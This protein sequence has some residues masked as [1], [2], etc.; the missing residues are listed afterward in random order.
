M[1]FNEKWCKVNLR[2]NTFTPLNTTLK[3]G[4][5]QDYT[6]PETKM[7]VSFTSVVE[8]TIQIN[9]LKFITDAEYRK[10]SS[11]ILSDAY[12]ILGESDR[13]AR[14]ARCS[15]YITIGINES[16][17]VGH[18]KKS[19][20]YK[21][22][23]R[24]CGNCQKVLSH[25]KYALL[26][27]ALDESEKKGKYQYIFLTLTLKNVT[28]SSL[29]ITLF[30]LLKA[31]NRFIKMSKFTNSIQGWYRSLEITHNKDTN[32]FHPHIHVLLQ[33]TDEYFYKKSK[34]FITQDTFVKMWRSALER[35]GVWV[36]K[37]CIVDIRKVYADTVKNELTKYICKMPDILDNENPK[38]S[39]KRVA[40][41]SDAISNVRFNACGGNIKKVE[42]SKEYKTNRIAEYN[43]NIET[44]KFDYKAFQYKPYEIDKSKV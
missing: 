27:G 42:V 9:K 14:V 36:G 31:Y 37:D 8:N 4:H 13:S 25:K 23:D 20:E 29:K 5:M 10:I 22:K 30:N 1:R 19:K 38:L 24:L 34:L 26:C 16:G 43:K 40:V 28:G 32:E 3:G 35:Q 17:K 15:S 7:Q 2:Q 21:C 39:T 18:V 44:L 11:M 41:L 6:T 33:V 12:E